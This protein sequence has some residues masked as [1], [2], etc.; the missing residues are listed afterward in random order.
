MVFRTFDERLML[1]LHHPYKSP[2]ERALL[3]APED[4][5][6]TLA[7]VQLHPAGNPSKTLIYRSKR[8]SMTSCPE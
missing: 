5:G 1:I 2:E 3:F 8:G 4:T 6:D 7:I